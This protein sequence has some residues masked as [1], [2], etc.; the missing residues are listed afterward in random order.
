MELEIFKSSFGYYN[1]RTNGGKPTEEMT[2]YLKQNGYRWSSHN[3]CWYPATPEAKEKNLHE[4]FVTEFQ[5]R[6][7]EA[8]SEV[9]EEGKAFMEKWQ[10]DKASNGYVIFNKETKQ[11]ES[12]V[13]YFPVEQVFSRD[14]L[15]A[16]GYKVYAARGAFQETKISEISDAAKQRL[17]E[18]NSSK[19][20]IDS[21]ISFTSLSRDD[22]IER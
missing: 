6:F 10:L 1:L 12:S 14:V 4:D 7:F 9:Q 22:E 16:S 13:G 8:N 18:Q 20:H 19:N 15:L 11:I 2:N 21:H 5:K 3:N 17:E